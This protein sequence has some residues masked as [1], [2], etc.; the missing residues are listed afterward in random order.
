MPKCVGVQCR[1]CICVRPGVVHECIL[2]GP[3]VMC[4]ASLEC[5]R[6]RCGCLEASCLGRREEIRDRSTVSERCSDRA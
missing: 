1:S 5:M 3:G 6:V 2:L 4:R